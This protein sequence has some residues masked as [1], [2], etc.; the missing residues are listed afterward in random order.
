MCVNKKEQVKE[1]LQ[2]PIVCN[3]SI[4]GII[5]RGNV[6]YTGQKYYSNADEDMSD[7]AVGFYE[8]I[9]SNIL[10]SGSILTKLGDFVD[11][12]F[13][14][15]TMNSFNII[16]NT[17][18][19]NSSSWKKYLWEF[20]D[21]YHC[22]ANFWVIPINIGR[23]SKKNNHYDSMDIFLNKVNTEFE[24]L[25][26]KYKNYFE[27]IKNPEEFLS[28]HFVEKPKDNSKIKEYYSS[29]NSK[30]LVEHA[31]NAIK[32]RAGNISESEYSSDLWNY[33]NKELKLFGES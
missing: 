16:S 15:D 22:L 29:R 17:Y 25:S 20:F 4:K 31:M 21:K 7:F 18:N 11:K 19:G 10:K 1:I 2:M 5:R 30:Q 23:K 26:N 32:E 14:G 28:K 24:D 27:N 8:I 13:A 3:K 12:N 33:F 9:Y 6:I